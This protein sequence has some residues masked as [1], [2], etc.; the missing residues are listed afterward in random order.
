MHGLKAPS[1]SEVKRM[2]GLTT[3]AHTTKTFLEK[4]SNKLKKVSQTVYNNT[5]WTSLFGPVR[6]QQQCGSCWAFSTTGTLEAYYFKKTNVQIYM[7]P[8]QLVDCNSA[9][10]GCD[11][12]WFTGSNS[13]IMNNGISNDANYPYVGVN[14]TC[15]ATLTG[16]V[17]TKI[18]DFTSCYTYPGSKNN[19][20]EDIIQGFL[21]NGPV[22]VAV[23]ASEDF[24]HYD[25]GVY[26]GNCTAFNHAVILVG[27]GT[28]PVSGQ[29]FWIIRNSWTA[30]WGE[31]GYIRV[32]RN[33]TNNNSCFITTAAYFPNI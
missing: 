14:N 4:S 13:Y 2:E 19:C 1:A 5:N 7:S 15:N 32:F 17:Q 21:Q 31:E 33:L 12:G 24:Q 26:S 22:S 8:Q 10:H 29:Q 25:S 28:D 11:G 18:T 3:Q 6:D 20:T 9:N 30:G 27:F 16:N 23:D